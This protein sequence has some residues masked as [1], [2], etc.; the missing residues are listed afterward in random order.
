MGV[1][2]GM[3][4]ANFALSNEKAKKQEENQGNCAC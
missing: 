1:K 4:S 3:E 2:I